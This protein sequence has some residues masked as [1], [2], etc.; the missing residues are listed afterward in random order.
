MIKM[1]YRN[2]IYKQ[3]NNDILKQKEELNQQIKREHPRLKIIYNKIKDRDSKFNKKFQEI[4]NRKCV[5]CGVNQDIMSSGLFEVDHFIC[6]SSFEGN[7]VEAGALSNL[8]LSCKKCNRAKGDLRWE[9]KYSSV[10]EVD[11]KN[12]VNVFFRECDYSI[13]ICKQYLSDDTVN[14]FYNKLKFDEEIRRLD[15]LLM[16]MN[17]FYNKYKSDSRVKE[18][19]ESI[20]SLQQARN[21]MW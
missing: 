2:T 15:Y 6:E 5:Y 12:I 21:R 13:K 18:L 10:F 19:L 4:Y 8:V 20:H 16:N 11:S 3:F 17:D 14:E 7:S 9:E 1:D